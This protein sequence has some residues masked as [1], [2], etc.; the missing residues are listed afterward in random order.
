[1]KQS[2]FYI[3][4]LFVLLGL[5]TKVYGQQGLFFSQYIQDAMVFNP[6]YAGAKEALT[7]TAQYRMQWV[8]TEG[9]PGFQNFSAHAPLEHHN[10]GLGL[11]LSS[12]KVP[13]INQ[14]I[15]SPV[16]AYRIHLAKNRFIAAGL[17]G[18]LV[19]QR[20]NFGNIHLRD[21]DDPAFY[22]SQAA[23]SASFGTGIFYGAERF[24]AGLAIPD[25]FPDIGNQFNQ[26]GFRKQTRSYIVHTG[27]VLELNPELK[28]KP[29]ILIALPDRGSIYA[30]ANLHLLI[31]EVLWVGGSYRF[32][33]GVAF[34]TQLQLNPQLAFGYSY[35]IPLQQQNYIGVQSH[36]MSVQY[37]FYYVKSGVK[38]PRY[39]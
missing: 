32:Q 4:F 6:A 28:I 8:Q 33:Q 13:G 25:L 17:Q 37:R 36:E 14:Q 9:A 31:R 39:F 38:S 27:L 24:Y 2:K 3:C 34:M 10:I 16:F 11:R 5:S 7:L 19:R 23:L 29:N 22:S 1:M 21:P 26:W 12:D 20:P 35:D 18:S 30:D 15:V